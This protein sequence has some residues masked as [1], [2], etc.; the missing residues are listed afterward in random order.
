MNN[1]SRYVDITG[2]NISMDRYFTSI[3]LSVW[4]KQKKI[5]LVGTMKENRQGMPKYLKVIGDRAE[6]SAICV[7]NDGTRKM[8]IS[9]VD[10]KKSGLENIFLLTTI[11]R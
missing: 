7:Y 2:R 3:S 5:T 9:Y 1:V 6:K 11:A 10:K 8:M 4:L